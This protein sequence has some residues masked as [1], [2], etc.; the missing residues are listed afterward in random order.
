MATPLLPITLAT[1]RHLQTLAD[2]GKLK[3]KAGPMFVLNILVMNT[4]PTTLE[5][6][7]DHKTIARRTGMKLTAVKTNLKLLEK[8]LEFVRH[9]ANG[10]KVYLLKLPGLE[11]SSEAQEA[12][13]VDRIKPSGAPQRPFDPLAYA[14]VLTEPL[15][16]VSADLVKLVIEYHLRENPDTYWRDANIDSAPRLRAALPAM[17]KQYKGRNSARPQARSAVT[18]IS[19]VR[20]HEVQ[21][22]VPRPA[23]RKVEA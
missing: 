10:V 3:L 16:G 8:Y 17:V 4:N 1:T 12:P 19:P 23:R 2:G 7:V 5:V 11:P 14:D 13:E 15:A 20:E 22:Y 9:K 6:W 18:V 21:D